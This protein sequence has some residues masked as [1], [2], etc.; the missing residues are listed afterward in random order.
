M[1]TSTDTGQSFQQMFATGDSLL[2]ELRE[3]TNS[4]TSSDGPVPSYV[5]NNEQTYSVAKVLAQDTPVSVRSAGQSDVRTSITM[6]LVYTNGSPSCDE[7]CIRRNMWTGTYTV[8]GLYAES[9]YGDMSWPQSSSQVIDVRMGTS[10]PSGCDYNSAMS[11]ADQK[12]RQQYPNLDINGY[13]HKE[14]FIPNGFSCG[15]AGLAIVGCQRPQAAASNGRCWSMI[16]SSMPLV[17][18][19]E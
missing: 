11:A 15:W 16:K 18:A 12:A 7:A 14:Y 13:R 1:I 5:V 3:V 9:S 6:R 17:Q 4:W 10:I 2:L 19:H 8:E